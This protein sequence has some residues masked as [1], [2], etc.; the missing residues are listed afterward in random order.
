M[1]TQRY[2]F[3]RHFGIAVAA[4]ALLCTGMSFAQAPAPAKMAAPA[5]GAGNLNQTGKI[6]W[7]DP[8][9]GLMAAGGTNQLKCFSSTMR[10][11]TRT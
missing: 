1:T 5:A 2:F 4:S 11:W 7:L 8:L 3:R 6:G 10:R 9:S